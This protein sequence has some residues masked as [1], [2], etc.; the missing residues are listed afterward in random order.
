MD[1]SRLNPAGRSIADQ[2]DRDRRVKEAHDIAQTI[3]RNAERSGA[4]P[5]PYEFLEL[6]GKGAYGKVYKCLDKQTNNLVAVKIIDI[7][8]QDWS[9]GFAPGA[10]RDTTIKDFKQEVSILR[11]LKDNNAKNINLIHDAF[12][13]HSQLWIVAD[14]CTGGSVRT[15]MRPFETNGKPHGLPEQYVV[16]IA[17]ELAVAMKSMHDLN[18]MHRDIK[19]ANVY[20]TEDGDIQLGDF[21]IVGVID[22]DNEKRKTVVGT[23]HWM[24]R[25]IIE[26][27]GEQHTEE[28]YGYE[29]DVWSFGCTVFEMASGSPPYATTGIQFLPELLEESPPRLEGGDYSD[30]L[31]DFVAFCLNPD[32][33]ARPNAQA[34]LNH[35]YIK[36]TSRIYPTQTLVRLIEKFKIW[37]H[38]GGSRLSLWQASPADPRNFRTGDDEDDDRDDEEELDWNFST[39]EEFDQGLTRRLSQMPPGASLDDWNFNSPAG[40]GLPPLQPLQTKNLTVAERIKQEHS[41]KSASRGEKSLNKVFDPDDPTGYVL[42]TPVEP[43]QPPQ[44]EAPSDLP[45]RAYESSST[46]RESVVVMLDLDEAVTP[47]TDDSSMAMRIAAI[48]EDTVRPMGRHANDDDEEDDYQY[49]QHSDANRRDTRAWTFS[50]A[51]PRAQRDTMAWT[52]STAVPAP[53]PLAAPAPQQRDTIAWSF[54]TAGLAAPETLDDSYDVAS[55]SNDGSLAQTLRPHLNHTATEPISHFRGLSSNSVLNRE[56]VTSLI[57]LDAGLAERVRAGNEILRPGT[58]SSHMTDATSGNPFDLEDDPEQK[59]V[60]RDRFSY[61]KPYASEGGQPKRLSH[62]T[63]PMHARGSSLSSTEPDLEPS[64]PASGGFSAPASALP[65]PDLSFS[66]LEQGLG[67]A[68][69]TDSNQWPSFSDQ[70]SY[71][72]SP[73]FFP[74]ATDDTRVPR[75]GQGFSTEDRAFPRLH[76]ASISSRSREPSAEPPGPEIDFPNTQAPHP[77]VLG[78]IADDQLMEDELGRI[79]S[80]CEYAL[81]TMSRVLHQHAS[82]EAE[83]DE[84]SSDFDSSFDSRHQDT[85]EEDDDNNRLTARRKP[86]KLE[87]RSSP[88]TATSAE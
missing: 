44:P 70:D 73:Q 17:R 55:S 38:G 14:Y 23:P 31:R 51:E 68:T 54:E 1:D 49:G 80:S 16:P 3:A 8:E 13:W 85:E 45:L 20:I 42:A 39:S 75:L 43:P 57:D 35:P 22:H 82:I 41:E 32:K 29:V 76:S 30:E 37:E 56:S 72:S 9:E 61:H 81:S 62:K 26:R 50:S 19:C 77:D 64:M 47:A 27:L 11:Q 5:P 34:L 88:R 78:E 25:E 18:I 40:S 46:S 7:D 12:D 15:L 74:S 87:M 52:F 65:Q 71:T 69:E 83:D 48:N 67:L 66:T 24:P 63:M 53:A 59:E 28:G 86:R 60:D 79:L 33:K 4:S 84:I 58:A 36:N 10:P 6:I 2:R 21:G